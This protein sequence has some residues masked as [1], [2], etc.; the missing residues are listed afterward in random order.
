[1][2]LSF[3][4]KPNAVW[5]DGKPILASDYIFTVKTLKNKLINSESLRSFYNFI[6]DMVPDP[7]N[8]RKFTIFSKKQLAAATEIAGDL[9]IMPEHIYDPARVMESISFELLNKGIKALET[10]QNFC[11]QF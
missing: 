11:R 2:S 1:M 6:D 9:H 10:N 7:K 5:D 4:I 3:E 8:N